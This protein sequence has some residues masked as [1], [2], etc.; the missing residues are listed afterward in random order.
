MNMRLLDFD[1]HPEHAEISRPIRDLPGLAVLTRCPRGR[2]FDR[3][4]VCS[5]EGD[6][7]RECVAVR[8][9]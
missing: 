2:H 6:I 1:D 3:R 5:S 8:T 7:L 4:R 9:A